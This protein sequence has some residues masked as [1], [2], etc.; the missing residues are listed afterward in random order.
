MLLG[1]EFDQ[2]LRRLPVGE[3]HGP[4]KSARG[5]HLVRVEQHHEPRV[6]PDEELKRRLAADW[7]DNWREQQ[8]ERQ[9]A[10]LRQRYDVVYPDREG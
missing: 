1:F 3:W 7:K 6:L 8:R 4:V 2:A 5:W 9:L 10:Q